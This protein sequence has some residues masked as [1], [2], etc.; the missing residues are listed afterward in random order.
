[1]NDSPPQER[2]LDD[3]KKEVLRRA[4]HHSPF[5][6]VRKDDVEKIMAGLTSLDKDHWAEQWSKM[7]LS[8]EEKGDALAKQK[9]DAKQIADT[10]MLGFH[11]C[12]LG[13]YPVASTP[14]KKEAYRH[15]LRIF[16]KAATH[17]NPPLQVV[18][19]GTG[20]LKL[21]GYLQVPEGV[22]KT[23]VVLHWGGVDGW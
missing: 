18:E 15:S 14:G 5:E 4:A 6:G 23:P 10:Y 11:Y 9:A 22:A 13:R 1:M 2:T 8:Y 16:H 12:S 20:D 3:V 7:G 21:K 17:F 19:Y